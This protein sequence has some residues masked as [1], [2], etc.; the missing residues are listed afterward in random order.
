MRGETQKSIFFKGKYELKLEF[1][2]GSGGVWKGGG[3]E[4][5]R[6][7][8]RKPLWEGYGYFLEHNNK[9]KLFFFSTVKLELIIISN[10]QKRLKIGRILWSCS[11]IFSPI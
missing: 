7:K 10:Q 5:W 9:N 6:F 1:Q 3:E 4:G 11:S 2:E 8:P